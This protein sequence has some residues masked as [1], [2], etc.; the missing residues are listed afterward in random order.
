MVVKSWG[1]SFCPEAE[2]FYFEI[3]LYAFPALPQTL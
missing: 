3:S 1:I 2:L